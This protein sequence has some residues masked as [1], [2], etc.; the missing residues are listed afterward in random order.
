MQ[1][2]EYPASSFLIE[3]EKLQ[4]LEQAMDV[5]H[6]NNNNSVD[7]MSRHAGLALWP[8]GAVHSTN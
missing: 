4:L 5:A 2:F 1:N 3:V 7:Y 6:N 8:Y